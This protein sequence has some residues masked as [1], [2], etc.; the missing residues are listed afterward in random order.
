M[1]QQVSNVEAREGGGDGEEG[2]LDLQQLRD[3]AGFVLRAPLRHPILAGS[4][5]ALVAALGVTISLTMPKTYQATASLLAQRSSTIRALSSPNARE[6]EQVDDPMKDVPAMILRRD[7]LVT[8]VKDVDLVERF[9]RTRTPA[10]SLKDRVMAFVFGPPTDEEKILIQVYTLEKKLWV[11]NSTADTLEFGVTWNSARTAYDI[12]TQLQKNFLE[13]RY[14]S[15]IAVIND[16]I[17]LL[18]TRAKS[19]LAQVDQALAEYQ[20]LVDERTG[21]PAAHPPSTGPA[22]G[23]TG[24]PA[25][26][27]GGGVKGTTPALGDGLALAKQLEEKRTQ[28]RALEDTRAHTLDTLRR[29]LVEARLTLT[30]LH[31]TVVALQQQVDALSDPSPDL[32]RLRTE[33]RGLMDQIAAPRASA[34]T[35]PSAPSVRSLTS[36]A[37]EQPT[38]TT[39]AVAAVNLQMQLIDRDG[40]LQL[41]QSKLAAAA[42]AYEETMA[43]LDSA[44]VELDIT[45]TSFKHRYTV[46]QPAE[47]PKRPRKPVTQLVGIGSVVGAL[48][49]AILLSA[50]VDLLAG[51]VLESWQVQRRLNIEVLA[52]LEKPAS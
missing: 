13:A 1:D 10:L 26:P 35:S 29:Q 48:L 11:T 33:E 44:K 47:L 19:E 18:E 5:F 32:E 45:R 30:P 37:S 51:R 8:L 27:T 24:V 7:N 23:P 14:D 46:L 52:E 2:G 9:E 6:M 28:I 12:I 38:G 50:G 17:S 39:P 42:R 31:P 22:G 49:L 25:A 16:G 3:I 20:K 41:G 34:S 4:T 15:D 21:G 43:R 40:P 36:S